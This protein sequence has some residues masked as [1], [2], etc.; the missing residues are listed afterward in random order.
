MATVWAVPAMKLKQ[1]KKKEKEME[2]RI[3]KLEEEVKLLRKQLE[4][5]D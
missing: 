1:R 4:Q 3:S 5:Q 2:E